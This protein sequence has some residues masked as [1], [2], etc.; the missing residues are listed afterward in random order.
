[1]TF[2]YEVVLLLNGVLSAVTAIFCPGGTSNL[3]VLVDTLPFCRSCG[4]RRIEVA[5]VEGASPVGGLETA[6][7]FCRPGG[8]WR[9]VPGMGCQCNE[10]YIPSADGNICIDGACFKLRLL[11]Q[12][13]Y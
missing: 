8:R 3:V 5:C 11:V 4:D 1:M 12:L 6:V 2:F 13:V 7:A 9:H 10:Q